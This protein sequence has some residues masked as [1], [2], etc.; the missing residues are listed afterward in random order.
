MK[1]QCATSNSDAFLFK[2]SLNRVVGVCR[3]TKII[4]KQSYAR[5]GH[6]GFESSPSSFANAYVAYSPLVAFAQSTKRH[7]TM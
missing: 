6:C 2:I 4:S 1:K 7:K 5:T 3:Y